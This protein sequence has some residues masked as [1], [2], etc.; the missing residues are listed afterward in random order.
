MVIIQRNPGYSVFYIV[1]C[2]FALAVIYLILSAPFIAALQI[3]IYAGSIMILFLIVLMMTNLARLGRLKSGKIHVTIGIGL[4]VILLLE[5]VYTMY[6][7]NLRESAFGELMEEMGPTEVGKAI[8]V[9]YSLA[10]EITSVLLLV[11][12]VGALHLARKGN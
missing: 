1:V 2:F 9:D 6:R 4:G 5:A 7:T 3:I 10:V 8:F 11:A 12:M